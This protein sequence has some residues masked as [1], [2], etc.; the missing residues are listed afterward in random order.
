MNLFICSD[1]FK[2]TLSSLRVN[3]TL[4]E[5]LQREPKLS[6]KSLLL[7]DGGEG[8]LDALQRLPGMQ[9]INCIV[10]NPIGKQVSSYYLKHFKQAYIELALASGI[11]L[12]SKEE[13]NPFYTHSYGTGELIN[14]AI[15]KGC[16]ELFLFLG[17]SAMV[18]GGKG[19]ALALLDERCESGNPLMTRESPDLDRLS[20]KLQSIKVHLVTDVSNRITGDSGAAM[21]FGPQKGATALQLPSLEEAMSKWV[22]QLSSHSGN[23]LELVD[24]LGAAGGAGLPLMAY[25]DA[26]IRTGFDYFNQIL[27]YETLIKWADVVIT[28]EG[29]IDQQ[30]AMGK[31]PGEI[32]RLAKK[33]EKYVIGVGGMV[34]H[35]PAN[36]DRIFA[37]ANEPIA[38]PNLEEG[39]EERLR[40]TASHILSFIQHQLIL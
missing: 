26:Q 31:G 29:C 19:L 1:S 4:L 22:K 21:V 3:Q 6:C 38:S 24:G 36:F 16:N 32:A 11:T 27:G 30:T 40:V 28:G 13:L 8:S 9:R 25:A 23:N 12:I 7:A 20:K 5:V 10:E 39:A 18:D 2:G 37:T 33:H 14:N 34:K 17:G 35:T 15:S